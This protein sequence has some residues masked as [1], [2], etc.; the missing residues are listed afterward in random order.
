MGKLSGLPVTSQRMRPGEL[1]RTG[2]LC[3]AYPCYAA[4]TAAS[5]KSK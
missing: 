4:W 3:R 1:I 5:P 2:K